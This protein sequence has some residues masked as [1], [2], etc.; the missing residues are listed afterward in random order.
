[1]NQ[2]LEGTY[3]CS[4]LFSHPPGCSTSPLGS[5]CPWASEI[6]HTKFVMMRENEL[7]ISI[8]YRHKASTCEWCC[9]LG[10]QLLR[11]NEGIEILTLGDVDISKWL[12]DHLFGYHITSIS[13]NIVF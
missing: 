6:L 2:P 9:Q 12:S 13:I 4:M 1:M 7:R 8:M 3:V 10:I 11:G 5:L